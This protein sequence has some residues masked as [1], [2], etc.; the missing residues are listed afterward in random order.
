MKQTIL[1]T[2]FCILVTAGSD[3]QFNF[4]SGYI[5]DANYDTIHGQI[6][7]GGEIR[8]SRYCLFKAGENEKAK[9]YYPDEIRAYRISGK[10]SFISKPLFNDGEMIDVFYEVLLEGD[11]S[12]YYQQKNR[13]PS[14][15]ITDRMGNMKT[16]RIDKVKIDD[17]SVTGYD[18]GR[19][20]FIQVEAYKDT[21]LSV[22]RDNAAIASQVMNVEYNAKSLLNITRAYLRQECGD[23][24]CIRFEKDL[25]VYKNRY[26]IFSGTHLTRLTFRSYTDYDTEILYPSKIYS[27]FFATIPVGINVNFPL[28]KFSDNLSFQV[29]VLYDHLKYNEPFSNYGTFPGE[30]FIEARSVSFPV[31]LK[32]EL[33]REILSPSIAF[34]KETMR[35]FNSEVKLGETDDLMV[36]EVQ[37][38]GFFYQLGFNYRLSK[39]ISLFN[40]IR[41]RSFKN[42]VV[43]DEFITARYKFISQDDYHEMEY[44]TNQL[45]FYVGITF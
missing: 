26:G 11:I 43:E 14:F 35:V 42:I 3:A 28:I 34:G 29:E 13:A 7:D 31:L 16:L 41:F 30:V 20:N 10:K 4:H 44:V 21:L 38:G 8:N 45:A 32:Y 40:A 27:K 12:L 39:N 15:Y 17:R 24:P 23:A 5:I 37:K 25:D 22:F 18:Y 36:H 9:K 19:Y 1:I 33:E 6:N 2:L